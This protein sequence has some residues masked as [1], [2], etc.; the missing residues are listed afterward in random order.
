MK[1][2]LFDSETVIVD[3]KEKATFKSRRYFGVFLDVLAHD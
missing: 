2:Y 3:I 1:V